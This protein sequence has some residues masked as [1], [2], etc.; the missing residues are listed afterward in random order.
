MPAAPVST[1]LSF[2][3]G[4]FVSEV[5]YPDVSSMGHLDTAHVSQ[6]NRNKS[7]PTQL[8][9]ITP[10]V[11]SGYYK[12]KPMFA[13]MLKPSSIITV[14]SN[15]GSFEYEVAIPASEAIVLEDISGS[16]KPGLGGQ[17]FKVRFN[18][19]V[20]DHGGVIAFSQPADIN[21][22]VQEW[23]KSGDY[24]DY[25]LKVRA[26][27]AN[28]KY[29]LKQWLVAGTRV[30][31]V[32]SSMGE[33]DTRYNS[34]NNSNLDGGVMKFRNYTGND[35]AN[36]HYTC[37]KE[38]AKSRVQ[39]ESL[40]SIQEYSKMLVAHEFAPGTPGYYNYDSMQSPTQI[41]NKIANGNANKALDLMSADIVQSSLLP[42]I[43]FQCHRQL[44][45]DCYNDAMFGMGG[46][47]QTAGGGYVMSPVGAWQQM[48]LG[49]IHGYNIEDF[50]LSG[51]E[52]RLT[53]LLRYR[54]IPYALNKPTVTIKT[55][56]GGL[57]LVKTELNKRYN[58][59]PLLVQEKSYVTGNSP[60][61]ILDS[62]SFIGYQDYPYA[63]IIFEY[64]Q[65]LEPIDRPTPEN[66]NV[67]IALGNFKLSGFIYICSDITGEDNNV[68][69]LRIKDDWDTT[70]IVKQG[71]LAYPGFEKGKSESS[72]IL[73]DPENNRGFSVYFEKR[74]YAYHIKDATKA[75]IYRP[76]NKVTGR[77]IYSNSFASV[78][79]V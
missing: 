49:N 19:F 40:R 65:S 2:N 58:A 38:G 24:F 20:T 7:N 72:F 61:Q 25:T 50:A 69:E 35:I 41:Y 39:G 13:D 64:D 55:G 26:V 75:F 76:F 45:S 79:P 29:A 60:N 67:A 34:I 46:K 9:M 53:E 1:P 47:S 71:R 10:F 44:D 30:Y 14:D 74:K 51:I 54:Q 3:N 59:L 33:Y 23:E 78:Y 62:P 36:V 6:L 73:G 31:V 43:E 77:Q 17:P 12:N 48:Q 27:N 22:T 4:I 15:D 28:E 42:L 68:A 56:M 63:N 16:P 70:Q 57:A 66:P 52:A 32:T 5:M 18:K 11:L 8:G 21:F 37:T